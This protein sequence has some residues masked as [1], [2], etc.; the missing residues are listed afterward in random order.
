MTA[1]LGL[2]QECQISGQ[3]TC[4]ARSDHNENLC[5]FKFSITGQ[6]GWITGYSITGQLGWI[7]GYST[8]AAEARTI[9]VTLIL[10]MVH[11]NKDVIVVFISCSKDLY[12]SQSISSV[13]LVPF[14]PMLCWWRN[15][16]REAPCKHSQEIYDQGIHNSMMPSTFSWIRHTF[17][18][19]MFCRF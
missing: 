17:K 16:D 15:Q 19:S 13:S 5:V 3:C 10:D 18:H 8:V 14:Q 9:W 12:E 11:T 4:T 6:L 7:T 1:S 2:S